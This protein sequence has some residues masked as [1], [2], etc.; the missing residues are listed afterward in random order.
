VNAFLGKYA[1]RLLIALIGLG[2]LH[3]L[4]RDFGYARILHD[5]RGLGL[6]FL[7]VV[8]WFLLPFG[9][10]A[11]GWRILVQ[12]WRAATFTYLFLV[13]IVAFAWNNIGPV[14]KSLGEPTRVILLRDRL[15]LREALRSM[16]LINM[17][18]SMG[19]LLTFGLGAA[20]APLFFGLSDAAFWIT[21]ASA[22]V[23]MTANVLIL[24]WIFVKRS[25]E[26]TPTRGLRL[27]AVR[28]WLR[29]VFHQL[30]KYTRHHPWRFASAVIL[31]AGSRVSEGVVFYAVFR[32]LKTPLSLWES[33]ALDTGRGIADNAFFFVPYQLGTR[34]YSLKFLTESVLHTGSEAAIAASLVFRL[35]EISWIV[36]GFGLGLLLMRLKTTKN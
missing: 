17:A 3:L 4:L 31:C 30:R 12:E 36:M 10:Q 32:A 19:T 15:P 16:M 26:K 33:I 2:G 29:W 24:L 13:S 1:L 8:L 25:K 18:Q 5:L 28:H 34:E 35:G 22:L 7:P 20:V 27:R 21:V 23:A 6:D 9:F 14:S 11:L